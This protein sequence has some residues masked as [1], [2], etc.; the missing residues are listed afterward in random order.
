MARHGRDSRQRATDEATGQVSEETRGQET[1]RD[2][3]DERGVS[4]LLL[5]ALRRQ[6]DLLENKCVP[7]V[8][9]AMRAIS[10]FEVVDRVRELFFNLYYYILYYNIIYNNINIDNH[11]CN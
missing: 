10:S 2:A 4:P 9:R 5:R 7:R 8:P 1:G 11:F 6:V 3:D